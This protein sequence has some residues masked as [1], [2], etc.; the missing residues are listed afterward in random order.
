EDQNL[1]PGMDALER[2]DHPGLEHERRLGRALVSLLRRQPGV[3]QG[4]FDSSYL[5]QVGSGIRHD[6]P[7]IGGMSS[8][9]TVSGQRPPQVLPATLRLGAVHLT[10]ADLERSIAWYERALGL[11]V[12][13]RDAE[14]A[15][16][17]D[18]AEAVVVV[19]EDPQARP[20]GRHAG[21]FHYALLYPTRE[22]LARAALRVLEART[23]IQGMS[24]H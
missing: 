18:G 2:L 13:R 10:V 9:G 21:L 6:P 22:E 14:T 4:R 23:P 7:T 1:L 12:Q 24:D 5:R 16:L 17:G 19:H 20:A 8:S 11:R 3:L 15:E